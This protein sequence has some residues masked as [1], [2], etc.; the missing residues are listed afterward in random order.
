[1]Q[2]KALWGETMSIKQISFGA[3]GIK[4]LCYI[5]LHYYYFIPSVHSRS[6]RVS[7]VAISFTAWPYVNAAKNK[8]KPWEKNISLVSKF[9]KPDE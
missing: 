1:M 6:Q 2:P 7:N 4:C 8:I 3:V 9:R 5:N